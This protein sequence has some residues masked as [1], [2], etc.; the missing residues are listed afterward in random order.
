MRH[1]REGDARGS[2]QGKCLSLLVGFSGLQD[3]I[4]GLSRDYIRENAPGIAAYVEKKCMRRV[5]DDERI[6]LIDQLARVANCQIRPLKGHDSFSSM[7]NSVRDARDLVAHGDMRMAPQEEVD[8]DGADVLINVDNKKSWDR[9]RRCS[10]SP[11][12]A[13]QSLDEW[14][15]DLEWL[16]ARC[17]RHVT[18]IRREL[19]LVNEEVEPRRPTGGPPDV[20]LRSDERGWIDRI[21][22]K[23]E[24]FELHNLSVGE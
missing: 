9:Y 5:S 10:N 12:A 16:L 6:E 18:D 17:H 24:A 7:Y 3:A 4:E 11:G 15:E 20:G 2:I 22:P 19:G 14:F 13:G 8:R 1:H 21:T 23:L